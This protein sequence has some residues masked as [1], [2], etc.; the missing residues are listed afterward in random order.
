MGA[1]ADSFL[2]G[3]KQPVN[4]ETFEQRSKPAHRFGPRQLHRFDAMI[5]TVAARWLGLQNRPQLTRVQMTPAP[6]RLMIIQAAGLSAFGARPV[7]RRVVR[8]PHNHLT[9]LQVEV[10]SI[11]P[12]RLPYSQYLPVKIPILHSLIMR[13][14]H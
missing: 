4:R 5:G 7:R 10:H 8:Q 12:P 6:L 2:A 9:S 3:G 14:T 11:H 13:S 1:F